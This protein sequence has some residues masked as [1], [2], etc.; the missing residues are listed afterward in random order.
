[1]VWDA[2]AVREKP[3]R[4]KDRQMVGDEIITQRRRIRA[5]IRFDFQHLATVGANYFRRPGGRHHKTTTRHISISIT[6]DGRSIPLHCNFS[7]L[8]SPTE[9]TGI[10]P[11]DIKII[12]VLTSINHGGHYLEIGEEG[13]VEA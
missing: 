12:G 7:L 5:I 9:Q 8:L 1:M 6:W 2:E 11:R 13:H 10:W 4:Q 3:I